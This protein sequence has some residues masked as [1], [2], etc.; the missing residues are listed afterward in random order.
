MYTTNRFPHC[1]SRSINVF[2]ARLMHQYFTL[3][4]LYCYCLWFMS[5]LFRTLVMFWGL[6]LSGCVAETKTKINIKKNHL[7][8]IPNVSSER[9]NFLITHTHV[10]YTVGATI[11]RTY[12]IFCCC[13]PNHHIVRRRSS[14]NIKKKTSLR[15]R[16]EIK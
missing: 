8:N 3:N 16:C 5:F 2:S 13:C 6:L 1:P 7:L 14:M 12:N 15:S 11:V 4:H 10:A 9:N